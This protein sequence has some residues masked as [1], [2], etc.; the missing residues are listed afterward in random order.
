ML[1]TRKGA[2]FASEPR[3]RLIDTGPMLTDQHE[4][5]QTVLSKPHH[6]PPF[7]HSCRSL[8]R[9]DCVFQDTLSSSSQ[10]LESYSLFIRQCR[11]DGRQ[12]CTLPDSARHISVPEQ[13]RPVL[14]NN[15]SSNFSHQVNSSVSKGRPKTA[16]CIHFQM[17]IAVKR[18]ERIVTAD[19]LDTV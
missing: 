6:K 13:N 18:M 14:R 11:P 7:D 2:N 19:N 15:S 9:R 3:L 17:A 10:R 4:W 16:R 8:Q 5:I 1:H 12:H